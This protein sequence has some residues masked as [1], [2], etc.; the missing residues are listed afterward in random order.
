MAISELIRKRFIEFIMLRVYDDQYIDRQEEKEIL[1]EGIKRGMG[2]DEGLSLIRQVAAEKGFVIERVAEE[3][4]KKILHQFAVN[5][6][7]IDQKEFED[8]FALFKDACKGKI[9]DPALRKRLK[10]I[11]LDNG[12]KAKEGGF[13]SKNK[14][15]SSI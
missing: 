3:S 9:H 1:E 13:F 14:W 7:V 10:R 11:I 8:S 15:F 12:W 2:V 4:A 5:D 6:G